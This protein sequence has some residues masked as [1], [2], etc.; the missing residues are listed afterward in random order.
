M[1]M[2]ACDLGVLFPRGRELLRSAAGAPSGMTPT[3]NPATNPGG[4][5]HSVLPR[6]ILPS[7]VSPVGLRESQRQRCRPS[8]TCRRQATGR[9][10]LPDEVP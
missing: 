7:A 4:P 10:R 5:I 9:R 8:V 6:P 3:A 1:G 2:A